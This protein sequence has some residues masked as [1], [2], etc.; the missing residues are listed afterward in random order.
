MYIF[1]GL[2]EIVLIRWKLKPKSKHR[3]RQE[4]KNGRDKKVGNKESPRSRNKN[5]HYEFLVFR[6]FGGLDKV[7]ASNDHQDFT[8]IARYNK[9]PSR[10]V[11]ERMS[12][13]LG[14]ERDHKKLN[15]NPLLRH[16]S[17]MSRDIWTGL[18][19]QSVLLF[20]PVITSSNRHSH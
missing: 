9:V 7:Y 10:R 17:S 4:M 12:S 5:W 19:N 14:L 16:F 15:E 1:Q 2:L 8:V 3:H 13:H 20:L 18:I 11:L 6:A